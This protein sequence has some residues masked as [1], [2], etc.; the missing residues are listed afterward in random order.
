MTSWRADQSPQLCCAGGDAAGPVATAEEDK[1]AGHHDPGNAQPGA[2]AQGGGGTGPE[3]TDTLGQMLQNGHQMSIDPLT[4]ISAHAAGGA[5]LEQH[6]S[7]EFQ[8]LLHD[9]TTLNCSPRPS[10]CMDTKP[11][12]LTLPRWT[13][14]L[15]EHMSALTRSNGRGR[16][17]CV[18]RAVVAMQT[19][20]S[21]ALQY[22][23]HLLS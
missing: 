16:W 11:W 4:G 17:C 23:D 9:G 19:I 20:R 22:T 13:C 14:M 21:F 6:A 8:G 18:L 12:Y 1:E 3:A 15:A 5:L 10:T 7:N 2:P